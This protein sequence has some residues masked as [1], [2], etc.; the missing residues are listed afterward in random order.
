MCLSSKDREQENTHRISQGPG[1]GGLSQAALHTHAHKN[2]YSALI[3]E[4]LK[5]ISEKGRPPF[6]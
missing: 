3:S 6:L 4:V 1:V 2:K 5:C